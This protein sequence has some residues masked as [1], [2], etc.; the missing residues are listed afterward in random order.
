[1]EYKRM[2]FNH[3]VNMEKMIGEIND[4]ELPPPYDNDFK[5]LVFN[6]EK[7]RED[8]L[9]IA[10][11]VN[12]NFSIEKQRIHIA[13]VGAISLATFI[14]LCTTA[15]EVSDYL[16]AGFFASASAFTTM[17]GITTI[18][19]IKCLQ[20]NN[21]LLSLTYATLKKDAAPTSGE[22]INRPFQEDEADYVCAKTIIYNAFDK[23]LIKMLENVKEKDRIV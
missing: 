21:S 22:F 1:M 4:I 19:G 13:G 5:Q 12:K 17:A 6:D 7:A 9:K 3:V 10:D 20:K 11:F 2:K 23:E 14:T 18:N 16:F 8:F 15:S